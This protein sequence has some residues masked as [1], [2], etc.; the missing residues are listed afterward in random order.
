MQALLLH[1]DP[2][3]L[4]CAPSNAAADVLA[5]RLLERLPQLAER[6]QATRDA[7]ENAAS[8]LEAVNVTPPSRPRTA[9]QTR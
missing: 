4:V 5:L 1:P 9:P 7:K 3:I 6:M 8:W 2:R